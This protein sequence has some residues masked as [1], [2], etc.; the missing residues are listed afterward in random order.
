MRCEDAEDLLLRNQ[1]KKL[2]GVQV[3][4]LHQ[5]LD[6]CGRC[7]RFEAGLTKAEELLRR[8]AEA[9]L[10]QPDVASLWRAVWGGVGAPGAEGGPA[11][12]RRPLLRVA[13]AVAVAASLLLAFGLWRW[14]GE[15]R[16]QVSALRE[17]NTR[18]TQEHRQPLTRSRPYRT[19]S[20][21]VRLAALE[22]SVRLYRE[23]ADFYRLPV[24]WVVEAE[25]GVE[26]KL[27]SETAA[28]ATA[29]SE[30][31]LLLVEVTI[32]S[33]EEP[34]ASTAVRIVSHPGQRVAATLPGAPGTQGTWRLE[35][36]PEAAP[37]GGVTVSLKLEYTDGGGPAV[38]ATRVTLAPD[39]PLEV[40][41]L[42]VAG[43]TYRV[44][45]VARQS[46]MREPGPPSD[47]EGQA[48]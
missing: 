24:H 6:G 27:G 47:R 5:H 14:G 46:A 3:R 18:L 17:A 28:A 26:M 11:T 45:V 25:R 12:R 21:S 10:P 19:G 43:R 20:P 23:L 9:P 34:T 38:L 40:G 41:S 2:P 13:P 42:R 36:V 7:R 4:Q 33:G 48:I 32:L 37:Q 31:T 22:R 15:L 16:R 29:R 39:V 30:G 8:E 44:E 1:E 35:C